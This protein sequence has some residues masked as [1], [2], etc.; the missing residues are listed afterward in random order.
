MIYFCHYKL[1]VISFFNSNTILCTFVILEL[2]N[3]LQN[4]IIENITSE[5]LLLG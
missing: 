5:V 3:F 4:H 2:S 1:E